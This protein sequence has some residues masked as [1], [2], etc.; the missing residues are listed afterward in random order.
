M[1]MRVD[2]LVGL[3]F[4]GVFYTGFVCQVHK[5]GVAKVIVGIFIPRLWRK[6]TIWD[7]G[8]LKLRVSFDVMVSRK[9][10]L[11]DSI[12]FI[13]THILCGCRSS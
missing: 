12:H 10:V 5:K 1:I 13:C 2:S 3:R 9:Q 11:S 8:L 4:H 7:K 6:R